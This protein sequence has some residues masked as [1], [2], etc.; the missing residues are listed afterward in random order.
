MTDSLRA[1]QICLNLYK[2]IFGST[3][4]FSCKHPVEN[5]EFENES[6]YDPTHLFK[7]YS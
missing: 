6:L 1:N 3:D 5:D 7:K 4:I 2:E